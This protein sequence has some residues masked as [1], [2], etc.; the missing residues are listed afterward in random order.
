MGIVKGRHGIK[1][2]HPVFC[3]Y[4]REFM[5]SNPPPVLFSGLYD[6]PVMDNES[7]T[8]SLS[9]YQRYIPSYDKSTWKLAWHYTRLALAKQLRGFH[10]EKLTLSQAIDEFDQTKAPGWPWSIY[11]ASKGQVFQHPDFNWVYEAYHKS[12]YSDEPISIADSIFLKHEMRPIEKC[13]TG[14][15]RTVFCQDTVPA[16]FGVIHNRMFDQAFVS[17]GSSALFTDNYVAVGCTA[18]FGTFEKM[19]RHLEGYI[20][21]EIDGSAWDSSMHKDVMLEIANLRS[22]L[23]GYDDDTR[24]ALI[25]HYSLLNHTPSVT[26]WGQLID[27]ISGNPSGQSSTSID[28]SI[29]SVFDKF[30]GVLRM[31][32]VMGYKPSNAYQTFRSNFKLK[33]FGDDV[34][35]ARTPT[36][37]FNMD[38]LRAINKKEMGTVY[39]CSADSAVTALK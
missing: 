20:C 9:K 1:T 28:N 25:N 18:M 3:N 26:P 24:H 37:P 30:Y 4:F 7:V 19:A 21:N 11:C 12:M 35:M 33:A 27:R 38:I 16:V 29:Y 23:C 36:V 5:R 15:A 32:S 2:K 6:F 8:S 34:I 17:T 10:F 22:D 39:T 14:K 31:W 13:G